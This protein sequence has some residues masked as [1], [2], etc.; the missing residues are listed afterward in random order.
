MGNASSTHLTI[1]CSAKFSHIWSKLAMIGNISNQIDIRSLQKAKLPCRNW[2]KL[3]IREWADYIVT[4]LSS[5]HHQKMTITQNKLEWSFLNL[6]RLWSKLQKEE[7]KLT[8]HKMRS[9]IDHYWRSGQDAIR[10]FQTKKASSI[11]TIRLGE[12]TKL[13]RNVLST[14]NIKMW[15]H[16]F[17]S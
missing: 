15:S 6:S 14:N 17:L 8:V 7:V 4:M 12:I 2:S 9:T 11:K 10:S 5:Y 16:N 1:K 3:S 13:Q